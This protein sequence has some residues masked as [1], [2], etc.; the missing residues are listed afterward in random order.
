MSFK[1]IT[2]PFLHERYQAIYN[3]FLSVSNACPIK[4]SN[5]VTLSPQFKFIHL[6]GECFLYIHK[7]II[8]DNEIVSFNEELSLE[9]ILQLEKLLDRVNQNP[10]YADFVKFK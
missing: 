5:N 2:Q 8:N 3:K 10:K 1:I 9:S 6:D 7:I 4:L